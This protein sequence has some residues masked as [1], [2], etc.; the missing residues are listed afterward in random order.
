M[1][2]TVFTSNQPRHV[3]LLE[4][5]S[6]VADEVFAVQECNTVFPGQVDDFFRRSPVMQDY[7]ARVIAAEREVF[8]R[9][10]FAPANVR[11]LPIKMGDV[12]RLDVTTLGDALR[13]DLY[14]V[15]GASYIRGPL[16]DHLVANRA[17]NI[18]MGVS[19]YYRG[20][21]TNF[22]AMADGRPEMVGATVHR[23]GAGLDSGP[24][25]F[26]AFPTPRAA[27]P[28]VYGMRCVRSAHA[29]VVDHIRSGALLT[30]EPV[31]QNRTRELR[32]ARNADFTDAVAADYLG[33]IPSPDALRVALE[34][35]DSRLFVRPVLRD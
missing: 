35:R 7:F 25:L 34:A 9:P 30:L 8:G 27:E 2:I 29:A 10:R 26:H 19:P 13:A 21:S 15:F 6:A 17:V 22:W 1:R 31:A 24:I 32:Y 3:A 11:Q 14:L 18:H 33:R 12:S 23:L 16:C 28:F 5:L 4:Q 20:S